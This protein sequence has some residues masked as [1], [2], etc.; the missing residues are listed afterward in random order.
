MVHD[1]TRRINGLEPPY[2][3]LQVSTWVL[4]PI[5]IVH[6]FAFL[7]PLLWTHVAVLVLVT[8]TFCLS[9]IA[10]VVTGYICCAT[11]PADDSLCD[12][13]PH[14]TAE[15]VER[16]GEDAETEVFCYLCE[17]NVH[18]T[19]KHCR[20]CDKCVLGFDHHCKWLNTCIGT[21]NY[22]YFLLAVGFIA[23][24]TTLSLVLCVA[25]LI[26]AFV[27][28]DAFVDRLAAIP[29]R[30]LSMVIPFWGIVALLVISIVMLGPLVGLVYQVTTN[31]PSSISTHTPLL[32]DSP[33]P[34]PTD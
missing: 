29:G 27:N 21:K 26:D 22:R 8:L 19:S 10:G 15:N 31:P 28:N 33:P 16:E 20:V 23:V 34:L 25:L 7:F 3:H 32:T 13:V 11:D 9:S 5:I 6:Y 30:G 18:S 24:K 1:T 14:A 17:V 4:F 2:N 12:D